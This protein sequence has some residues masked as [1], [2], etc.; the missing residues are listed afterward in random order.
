M[1][2]LPLII[3]IINE[4]YKVYTI[5]KERV[6]E[7]SQFYLFS[8]QDTCM[9]DG[10]RNYCLNKEYDKEAPQSSEVFMNGKYFTCLKI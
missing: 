5:P 10:F 3:T 7:L 6:S 1:T 2:N 4:V 8:P 9:E